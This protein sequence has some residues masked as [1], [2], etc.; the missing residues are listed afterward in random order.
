MSKSK[1]WGALVFWIDNSKRSV[2][3]AILSDSK[4]LGNEKIRLLAELKTYRMS[5]VP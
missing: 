2:F 1:D 5:I 3:Q 4:E